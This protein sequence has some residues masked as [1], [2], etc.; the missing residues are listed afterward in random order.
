VELVEGDSG[1]AIIQAES[2]IR[3][4]WLVFLNILA[5]TEGTLHVSM[6][7]YAQE[8]REEKIVCRLWTSIR[9][10]NYCVLTT[11][12]LLRD[13]KTECIESEDIEQNNI[14]TMSRSIG[15]KSS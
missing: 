11:I 10:H 9:R 12:P 7:S 14:V 1:H 8:T 15:G 5:V 4:W 3:D 2:V 6:P 13:T